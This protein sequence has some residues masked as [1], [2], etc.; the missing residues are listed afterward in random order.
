MS[1]TSV[2]LMLMSG[3]FL[4]SLMLFATSR[5]RGTPMVIDNHWLAVPNFTLILLFNWMSWTE[6]SWPAWG[7][8]HGSGVILGAVVAV[9]FALLASRIFPRHW[10]GIYILG[11]G[12]TD[13]N[14]ALK[15]ALRSFD[16][17][18]TLRAEKWH[19]IAYDADV[20][21]DPGFGGSNMK[22]RFG[23]E[24]AREL[25]ADMLPLLKVDLA[26]LDLEPR[27][28]FGITVLKALFFV[29]ATL[30]ILWA[31]FTIWMHY[32]KAASL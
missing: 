31:L 3:S 29:G 30:A 25:A 20:Q 24:G 5:W 21:I 14:R 12:K 8:A 17:N 7:L 18:A 19:S 15:G 4:L 10:G 11:V 22:L 2:A 28:H 9:V 6:E 1:S 16:P 13:L 26:E 32:Y 23:G 27:Q